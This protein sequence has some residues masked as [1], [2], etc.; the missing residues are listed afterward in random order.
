MI[1]RISTLLPLNYHRKRSRTH[2]KSKATLVVGRKL[3]QDLPRTNQMRNPM[4]L[5]SLLPNLKSTLI[6]VNTSQGPDMCH[7]LQRRISPLQP[8]TGLLSPLG[9]SQDKIQELNTDFARSVLLLNPLGPLWERS[10]F[11]F[12]RSWNIRLD[13]I[14]QPSISPLPLL[15][16]LLAMLPWRSANIASSQLSRR[17]SLRL[18]KVPILR[19]QQ[20]AI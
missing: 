17:L 3:I 13:K 7:L 11:Q 9:P 4:N 15:K 14:S 19:K 10:P 8:D 2:T 20:S 6:R 12:S 1:P 16:L 18:K 5:G